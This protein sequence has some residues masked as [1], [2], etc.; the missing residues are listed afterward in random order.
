MVKHGGWG[1]RRRTSPCGFL[2]PFPILC[3][4]LLWVSGH[5]VVESGEPSD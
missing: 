5:S 3:Y 2:E 1:V 4:V